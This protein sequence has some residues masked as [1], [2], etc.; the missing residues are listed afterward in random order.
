[1]R[2]ATVA[3]LHRLPHPAEAEGAES[4]RPDSSGNR[5]RERRARGAGRVMR[6][7]ARAKG[8]P[9]NSSSNNNNNLRF[10]APPAGANM[11]DAGPA[12]VQD[13][14]VGAAGADAGSV[15]GSAVVSA[16]TVV[17]A[18][19]ATIEQ[20]VREAGGPIDNASYSCA[21]GMVFAA[22]VSTTVSCPHCGAGQAW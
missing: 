11:D 20:R 9:D 17:V 6:G 18:Q 3:L 21:C 16:M 13:A 2:R 5:P 14:A 4:G 7:R 12:P 22:A 8:A 19:S 1:M 10:A 15:A